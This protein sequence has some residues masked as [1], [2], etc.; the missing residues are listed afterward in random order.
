MDRT[1][2][3][4]VRTSRSNNSGGT[5]VSIAERRHPSHYAERSQDGAATTCD[6]DGN[7][8][9]VSPHDDD[10]EKDA[11]DDEDEEGVIRD[12]TNDATVV[13]VAASLRRQIRALQRRGGGAFP[14]EQLGQLHVRRQSEIISK[15]PGVNLFVRP[16]EEL[17]TSKNEGMLA[18]MEGRIVGRLDGIMDRFD[19][20]EGRLDAIEKRM[21]EA[22]KAKALRPGESRRS[23]SYHGLSRSVSI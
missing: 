14:G 9:L 17:T 3:S 7:T 15:I 2:D 18:D 13:A 12:A 23:H 16:F 21:E 8:R 22:G 19:V 5:L 4:E 6:D 10:A 11:G 20:I 1:S